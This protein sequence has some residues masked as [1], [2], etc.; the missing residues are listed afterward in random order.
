MRAIA[1][2]S[3]LVLCGINEF[4]TSSN[5][6]FSDLGETVLQPTNDYYLYTIV[7]VTFIITIIT[8]T[9][10]IYFYFIHISFY[11]FVSSAVTC[12]QYFLFI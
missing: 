8:I 9:I 5:D 3:L 12:T 7:I 2:S 6:S 11:Y 4:D 10:V 1:T